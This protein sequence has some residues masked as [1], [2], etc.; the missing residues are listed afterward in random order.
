MMTLLIRAEQGDWGGAQLSDVEAA[1]RSAA[2]SFGVFQE[3]EA[4]AIVLKP[5]ASKD[6]PP[7]TE[8]ATSPSGEFVIRLS[9]RG[10]LWN[11]L[12]YQFAHEFCHVVADS[13]TWK[14]DCFAWIEDA[15]CETA[16]LFAL[17]STANSWRIEPPYPSWRDY[18]PLLAAYAAER[19]SHTSRRLPPGLPFSSWLADHLT[20]LEA[21]PYRRDDNTII[22]TELLPVFERDRAAWRAA[23]FLHACPR[24]SEASLA[25]FMN[26]WA[27]AC[28]SECRD[29][30]ESIAVLL[31]VGNDRR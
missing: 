11:Q 8:A 29:V 24:S 9:V 14:N 17:R 19:T 16:A 6:D 2:A 13:R 10:N 3:N 25:D 26:G 21:D 4:V 31:G 23:R 20:F 7:M 30:V 22:A 15:L 28:P 27:M 1:A 12:I 5:T 18:A